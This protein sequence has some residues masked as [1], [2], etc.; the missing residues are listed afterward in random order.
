MERLTILVGRLNQSVGQTKYFFKVHLVVRFIPL[1][2]VISRPMESWL[3]FQ[4][5]K[6][7]QYGGFRPSLLHSK[8]CFLQ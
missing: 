1:V 4:A 5:K 6:G 2:G 7:V 8:S 3:Q